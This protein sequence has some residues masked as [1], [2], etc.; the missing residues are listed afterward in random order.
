LSPLE[1]LGIVLLGDGND[2][3][4]GFG[5]GRFDGEDDTDKLV[6]G[7]GSYTVSNAPNTSGFYTLSKGT[8]DMFV[9]NFE[10]ITSATNSATSFSF[11]SVIGETFTV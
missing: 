10:L 6:L 11:S 3:L 2:V 4:K 5:T 1:G 8:I 9:K 7:A